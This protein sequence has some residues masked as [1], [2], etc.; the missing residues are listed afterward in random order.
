M[1]DFPSSV[2]TQ[3]WRK[4][5][6][7]GSLLNYSLLRGEEELPGSG[8][9]FLQLPKGVYSHPTTSMEDT[10]VCPSADPQ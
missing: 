3:L 6:A 5:S 9:C 1:T 2:L 8:C 7:P 10:C 4:G